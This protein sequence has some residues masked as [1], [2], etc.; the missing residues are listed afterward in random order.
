[1]GTISLSVPSSPRLFVSS[2]PRLLVPVKV[3]FVSLL[4]VAVPSDGHDRTLDVARPVSDARRRE[5]IVVGA[6]R[7]GYP[8][9]VLGTGY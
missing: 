5:R 8:Q 6:P 9:A 1:M 7:F 2:S 3:G 4:G